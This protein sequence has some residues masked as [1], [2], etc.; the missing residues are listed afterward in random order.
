MADENLIQAINAQPP[1]NGVAKVMFSIASVC[2]KG[3]G[4]TI[5]DFAR[6]VVTY[7]GAIGKIVNLHKQNNCDLTLS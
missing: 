5:Q 6:L 7:K 2:P 4:R 3:G 1:A